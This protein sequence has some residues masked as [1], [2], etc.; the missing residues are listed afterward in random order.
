MARD[1]HDEDRKAELR[2]LLQG[3]SSSSYLDFSGN[4]FIDQQL[5]DIVIPVPPPQ[6][7]G[8][9][10]SKQTGVFLIGTL[11]NDA[12]LIVN[13]SRGPL[14]DNT[15]RFILYW[16][17]E[18]DNEDL[19]E[20]EV[21]Y[22]DGQ[23]W[24]TVET[25]E[26]GRPGY[27]VMQYYLTYRIVSKWYGSKTFTITDPLGTRTPNQSIFIEPPIWYGGAPE[28]LDGLTG[29]TVVSE[30]L[31]ALNMQDNASG[32]VLTKYRGINL[33]VEA[34]ATNAALSQQ[35]LQGINLTT[36]KYQGIRLVDPSTIATSTNLSQATSQGTSLLINRFNGVSIE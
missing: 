21:Q 9:L 5:A 35:T 28:Q 30:L 34:V 3:Y 7:T 4:L 15:G 13:K 19:S 29:V 24:Q 33:L 14:F 25:Y 32:L 1:I 31:I 23:A 20:V 18:E 22:W 11:N 26:R 17:S 6:F 12:R 8:E 27:F 10:V 2:S 16:A 36:T